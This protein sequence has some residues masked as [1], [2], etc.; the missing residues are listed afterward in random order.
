MRASPG[1]ATRGAEAIVNGGF[2]MSAAG[3]TLDGLTVLNGAMPRRQFRRHLR[4][5]RQRHP[6]Q[7][8]PRR[9]RHRPAG[10]R[11]HHLQWR[12]HRP[13]PERQPGHRLGLGRLFQPDDPVH[14][15]RQQL[16]RQRQRHRRRRLGT[17]TFIDGNS[18][19][20]STGSHI[21]YGSFDT[22][23]GHAASISTIRAGGRT[24]RSRSATRS[25][26][27]AERSRSSL[28]ATARP[29]ARRSPA[30]TIPTPSSPSEF[31]AGSGTNSTFN[32]LGGNDLF[33]GGASNDTLN[34]GTG[35]DT[36][37]YDGN[38]AANIR[39]AS[40]PA[41]AAGSSAS[42]RCPTTSRATATRASTR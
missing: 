5:C 11:H 9:R 14:R 23:R 38:R 25:T 1:P 36:A 8:G 16:R 20:N 37:V 12:H 41:P 40:S 6:R 31:V 30:P 10:R 2:Y 27:A 32:G 29:A 28:M 21:G 19:T 3:A 22:R 13:R 15:H 35:T 7:H 33:Y 34:G 26:P 24:S 17:G 4:Q 39:S 42:P 18:F